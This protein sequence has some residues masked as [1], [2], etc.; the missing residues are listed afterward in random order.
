MPCHT[1]SKNILDANINAAGIVDDRKRPLFRATGITNYLTN[2]ERIEVAQRM[3]GH[4]RTR[5]R[6]GSTTGATM[7]SA[8]ARWRKIGGPSWTA[9]RYSDCII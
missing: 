2:G 5:K 4:S 9:H 7:T 8:W 1:S 3:I 6:P